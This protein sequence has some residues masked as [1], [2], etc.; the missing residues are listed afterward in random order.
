[1]PTSLAMR[2]SG[3]PSQCIAPRRV[4]KWFTPRLFAQNRLHFRTQACH[5]LPS[6]MLPG[7]KQVT[8]I[9]QESLEAGFA[10]VRNRVHA[11]FRSPTGA[12]GKR[13][14]T[15]PKLQARSRFTA[16][17]DARPITP[18]GLSRSSAVWWASLRMGQPL[19]HSATAARYGCRA[20]VKIGPRSAKRLTPNLS[21]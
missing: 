20:M 8:N 2:A 4:E 7:A 12:L 10:G 13:G 19:S 11:R 5:T 21:T 9:F 17:S 18:A 14:K 15:A 3:T 16:P 6:L 1:M